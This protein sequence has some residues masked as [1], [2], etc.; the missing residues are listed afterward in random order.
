MR[1]F[2]LTDD[3]WDNIKNLALKPLMNLDAEVWVFGSRA[4]GSH[5]KFSDLDLLIKTKNKLPEYLL[6]NMRAELEESDLPIKVDLVLDEDLATSYRAS[7][8]KQ[9]VKIELDQLDSR[10]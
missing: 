7:V 9:K 4:V 2:G 1:K 3:Q 5:R 10:K 6:S 8:E